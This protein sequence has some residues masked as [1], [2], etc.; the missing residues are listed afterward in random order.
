MTY[1][2]LLKAY[3]T[4]IGIDEIEIDPEGAVFE[5]DGTTVI[6]RP[7]EEGKRIVL[8][9]EIA[10][11]PADRKEQVAE[12]LLQLNFATAANNGMTFA[13]ADDTYYCMSS[14]RLA[15]LDA[16]S[17]ELEM[18]ALIERASI[19]RQLLELEQKAADQD[20]RQEREAAQADSVFIPI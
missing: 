18:L 17:F 15:G 1:D 4:S 9:T 13:T 19:A 12:K 20:E 10:A 8:M 5:L 6:V 3:G 14:L 16:D 7:N 11:V 2:D